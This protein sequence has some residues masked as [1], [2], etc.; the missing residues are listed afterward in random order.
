[1]AGVA[2]QPGEE[3]FRREAHRFLSAHAR[4]RSEGA[5]AWGEGPD[6]VQLFV[7]GTPEQVR[8]Q[9][10]QAR[11]WR[12][13]VFDAGFGWISGPVRYGGRGLPR[14]YEGIYRSVE[15]EFDTPSQLPL[16]VGLGVVAPAILAHGTEAVKHAYL[17][18]LHRGDV[19]GCQLFSEPEAGSDLANVATT[20]V[21]DGQGWLLTGRKV[22]T[23]GAQYADL[24]EILCRTD[25]RAPRHEGMTAFVV[26]MATPGVEVRPIRHMSGGASF[27]EVLLEA[28]PVA[29]D[30]RLGEAGQGWGV[31]VTALSGERGTVGGGVGAIGVHR[32]VE[33]LRW[34]GKDRDPVLR[35]RLADVYV[36]C[37]VA[38]ATRLR[39]VARQDSGQP[40][41]P[42]SSI[43]RLGL[44][45]E[46]RRLSDFVTE[47]LGPR[48]TA[49]TGEWGTFAWAE[50]VLGAPGLRI[51]GGTDE[52]LKN[53]VAERVL[54]LPRQPRSGDPP[55]FPST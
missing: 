39:A 53:V 47:A 10:E 38:R 52:V 12:R 5:P 4:P 29:D 15:A 14:S 1:M 11:S 19:V 27:N 49:D 24:G 13:K 55:S 17:R 45:E 22:W 32:L 30:H 44:T 25:P 20:A 33:M 41:G 51:A 21:R 18:R 48:L 6:R 8:L 54:G 46:L 36:H 50:L 28:V 2:D 34:L 43:A 9:V 16:G 40:S 7:E 26:D 42:E 35:Q 23:S 31:A 37:A 3:R